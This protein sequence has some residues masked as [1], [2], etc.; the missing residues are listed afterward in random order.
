MK[1]SILSVCPGEP[2]LSPQHRPGSD[3]QAEGDALRRV[4][5]L[6]EGGEGHPDLD[7][8]AG[9]AVHPLTL[10]ARGPH[11]PDR[12]RVLHHPL[13]QLSCTC[14]GKGFCSPE[15]QPCLNHFSHLYTFT[16]V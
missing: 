3:H 2:F 6:H 12:L 4:H 11:Q 13:L 15:S 14:S 8:S 1:P 16:L 7:P 5:G 9:S 10:E